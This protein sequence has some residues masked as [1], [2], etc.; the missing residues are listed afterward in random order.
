MTRFEDVSYGYD[1]EVDDATRTETRE[2]ERL[3]DTPYADG[4]SL[5]IGSDAY[6]SMVMDAHGLDADEQRDVRQGRVG[7][8]RGVQAVSQATPDKREQGYREN[9][10]AD[11]AA[12][13]APV[14]TDDDFVMDDRQR[15]Q[16]ERQARRAESL[17]LAQMLEDMSAAL[18]GTADD[19]IADEVQHQLGDAANDQTVNI[20]DMQALAR[21]T[22]DEMQ[23]ASQVSLEETQAAK[24]DDDYEFGF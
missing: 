15:E 2:R 11:A 16:Y 3:Q 7:W 18:P 4:T 21:T 12:L 13:A 17:M 23:E 8:Q 5:E 19:A 1:G 20:D 22:V 24:A 10:R 9:L 14:S 6:R